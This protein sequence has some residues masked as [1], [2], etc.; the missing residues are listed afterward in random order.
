VG[1]ELTGTAVGLIFAVGQV[2][3]FVGP[4]V[5]GALRD[6]TASFAPGLVVLAAGGVVMLAAGLGLP[7]VAGDPD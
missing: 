7:S 6:A 4:F 1:A 3:G 5:V 2:G